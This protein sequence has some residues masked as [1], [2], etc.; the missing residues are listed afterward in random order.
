MDFTETMDFKAAVDFLEQRSGLGSVMGLDSIRNL[1]GE[2]SD[3][4]QDLKF[5]HI[6]GTNGKGSVS[7]CLSS[8]L[9]E[10]GCRTGTYTSPRNVNQP[11]GP[12]ITGTAKLCQCFHHSPS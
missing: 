5:V 2:L 4:Q 7:A 11:V 10:A 3:P 1:L 9:K 8:I 6:A 12:E